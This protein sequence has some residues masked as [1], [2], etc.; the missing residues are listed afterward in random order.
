M[1]Y[2][3][4]DQ[5]IVVVYSL[6]PWLAVVDIQPFVVPLYGA[7]VMAGM[8]FGLLGGT[9]SISRYLKKQGENAII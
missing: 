7:Y 6:V 3:A 2:F 1:L 9:I 8:L 5:L 4:Y